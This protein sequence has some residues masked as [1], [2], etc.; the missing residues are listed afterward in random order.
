LVL[1]KMGDVLVGLDFDASLL[2]MG[3]FAVLAR[4]TVKV[5]DME[6]LRVFPEGNAYPEAKTWWRQHLAMRV[7]GPSS[8]AGPALQVVILHTVSGSHNGRADHT[9]ITSKAKW[10]AFNIDAFRLALVEAMRRCKSGEIPMAPLR[11]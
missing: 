5:E 9:K 11:T 1:R 7:T 6:L 2:G 10:R 3:P 4:S 8:H